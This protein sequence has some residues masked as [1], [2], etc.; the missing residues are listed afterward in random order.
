[1]PVLFSYLGLDVLIEH[2]TC[3]PSDVIAMSADVISDVASSRRARKQIRTKGGLEILVSA[4]KNV[5][6]DQMII[7]V[8]LTQSK[9]S[10]HN[11]ISFHIHCLPLICY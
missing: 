5:F 4:F 11:I 1:M 10:I 9:C 2:L 8:G 7:D 6:I 3:G